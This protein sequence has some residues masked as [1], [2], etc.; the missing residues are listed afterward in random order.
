MLGQRQQGCV[1]TVAVEP[2][3]FI[4]RKAEVIADLRTRDTLGLVLVKPR[5]PFS[6]EVG[7]AARGTC[8][9]TAALAI[10]VASASRNAFT[11]SSLFPAEPAYQSVFTCLGHAPGKKRHCTRRNFAKSI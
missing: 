4:D 11:D 10:A 8:A 3:R 6:G 2:G 1:P 9:D 5:R 7:P